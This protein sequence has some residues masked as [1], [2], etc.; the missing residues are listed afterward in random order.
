MKVL[1]WAGAKRAVLSIISRRSREP[2]ATLAAASLREIQ[3]DLTKYYQKDLNENWILKTIQGLGELVIRETDPRDRRRTLY[4]INPE[5]AD[6]S[7][8]NLVKLNGDK[9][10]AHGGG[11][12][13]VLLDPAPEEGFLAIDRVNHPTKVRTNKEFKVEVKVN[14]GLAKP[15]SVFLALQPEDGERWLTSK[16]KVLKGDGMENFV[17]KLTAPENP[18]EWRLQVKACLLRGLLWSEVD[19]LP[20]QL[21]LDEK[22]PREIEV[23]GRKA[24]G[25]GN[26]VLETYYKLTIEVDNREEVE[27]AEAYGRTIINS[28]LA[29]PPRPT[30]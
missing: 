30:L 28:W 25:R 7:I 11:Y 13:G 29:E 1:P 19:S 26:H 2:D 24:E 17:L 16:T 14:Y 8:M 12:E 18:G 21:L 23:S 9:A 5:K 22:Y 10:F 15:A 6:R 4:R 3:N 27:E 20:I